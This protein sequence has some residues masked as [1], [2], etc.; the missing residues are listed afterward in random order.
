MHE[1]ELLFFRESAGFLVSFVVPVSVQHHV[2][3]V[4]LCGIHFDEWSHD[5]HDNF[6]GDAIS[7]RVVSHPLRMVAGAGSNHATLSLLSGQRED[8]VE[9]ATLLKGAGAL[10]VVE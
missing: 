5:R 7:P 3:A 9:S 8:L 6:G 1:C 2:G 4:S 10:Q